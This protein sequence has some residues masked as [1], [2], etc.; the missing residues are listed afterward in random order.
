MDAC[1]GLQLKRR[2]L[3]VE[4]IMTPTETLYR[5]ARTDREKVAFFKD[6]ET[7]T[8]ERLATEVE[9][10]ACG[11]I[12]SGLRQGDRVALHMANL[13]ELSLLITHVLE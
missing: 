5:R 3:G 8:Y 2:G 10:L 12:K 4:T 9:W 6:R 7:W 13:P 11:L 1:C